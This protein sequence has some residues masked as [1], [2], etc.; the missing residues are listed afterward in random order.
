MPLRIERTVKPTLT[1]FGLHHGDTFQFRLRSGRLWEMTLL[2]T[3]AR[4]LARDFNRRHHYHDPGHESG[5]ISAYAF[6]ADVRIN[7]RPYQL[8]RVVGTQESFYE[9]APIDGVCLWFDAVACL[10]RDAGGFMVEKDWKGE[11]LCKPAHAARFAVQEEGLPICPEPILPWYPNASAHLDISQCYDGEDCW[12]GPYNGAS[13]H[14]GLDINMP[15]GTILTAPFH[16]DAH[17]LF[18]STAAGFNNNRWRGIRRWADGS[19]WTI[20]TH[21]LIDMLVPERTSLKAGTPYATTAGTAI[22]LH[23]HTHFM[24]QIT[25]QGG[26]YRLDPWILFWAMG[27]SPLSPPFHERSPLC[28]APDKKK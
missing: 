13:A 19:L 7:G 14:C 28:I 9:P 2:A 23:P 20:Q 15:K 25:E 24:F 12:M 11:W 5:D 10:F 17:E 21:H 16:L 26:Q 6:T 3:R 4:I 27:H 1:P 22:G 18:H 8:R